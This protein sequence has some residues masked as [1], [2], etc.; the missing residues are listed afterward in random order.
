MSIV[1]ITYSLITLVALGGIAAAQ[2]M[3]YTVKLV[4]G[5]TGKTLP[6]QHMSIDMVASKSDTPKGF[7]D[8]TTDKDGIATISIDL[9]Q[10][11]WVWVY[12]DDFLTT[13][14]KK[15]DPG[16]FS[17]EDILSRGVSTPNRC[18]HRFSP[19]KDVPGRFVVY[20]REMS[21]WEKMKT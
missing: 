9:Q 1:K 7:Y 5:K 16:L 3:T 17:M 6:N 15:R 14:E 2:Q 12:V 21:F 20:T 13:C 8:A 11:K 4:D 19:E 10:D 18:R